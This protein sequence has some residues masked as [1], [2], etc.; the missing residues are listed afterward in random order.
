MQPSRPSRPIRS[1]APPW[2]KA[3]LAPTLN[4]SEHLPSFPHLVP[5]PP[6][7]TRTHAEGSARARSPH[8][9]PTGFVRFRRSRRYRSPKALV[10]SPS[11]R[12]LQA[13]GRWVPCLARSFSARDASSPRVRPQVSPSRRR[14]FSGAPSQSDLLKRATPAPQDSPVGAPQTRA[15]A[16]CASSGRTTRSAFSAPEF[17]LT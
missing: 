8:Q 2:P 15:V 14:P 9:P 17:P 3:Q 4:P 6:P 10:P 16:S 1:P 7:P 12:H 11:P 13:I 5:P